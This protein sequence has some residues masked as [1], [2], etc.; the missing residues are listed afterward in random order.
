MTRAE[1]EALL[2]RHRESFASRDAGRLAADHVEDGTFSSPAAGTV[3]G[4]AKIR[5]VYAYWLEAFPDME[6]TWRAPIIED[7]R[8][9]LFWR[10][11]G[12]LSGKF[13]GD[14]RSG[15]RIEFEDDLE[16]DVEAW[17]TMKV[18]HDDNEI[19]VS[20]GG[21]K[22][23]EEHGRFVRVTTPGRVGLV[24]TGSS[25]VWFDDWRVEPRQGRR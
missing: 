14:A 11:G 25:E 18:V 10:F 3:K 23:F 4:R 7:Q 13:F 21:I 20:L 19:A 17:H 15:T 12:T 8:A 2:D 1:I 9:A 24:A 6:F 5:D 16:L 22:V